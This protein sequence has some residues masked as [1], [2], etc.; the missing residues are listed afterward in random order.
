MRPS[1]QKQVARRQS[2]LLGV[3]RILP[4]RERH[5]GIHALG[6]VVLCT[7][8]LAA[9]AG[10]TEGEYWLKIAGPYELRK[11]DHDVEL[12]RGY[13]PFVLVKCVGARHLPSYLS[14][15]QYHELRQIERY[16]VANQIIVGKTRTGYFLLEMQ[17]TNSGLSEAEAFGYESSVQE[18]LERLLKEKESDRPVIRLFENKSDWQAALKGYGISP[19]IELLNPDDIARTRSNRELRPFLYKTF[20][21][22]LGLEDQYWACILFAVAIIV[23]FCLGFSGSPRLLI[24]VCSLLL[25]FI[26]GNFVLYMTPWP[27][28]GT[29]MAV[30][31]IWPPLFRLIAYVGQRVRKRRM[32]TRRAASA[33]DNLNIE[34]G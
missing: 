28:P 27:E 15:R 2:C 6:L 16:A 1:T 20:R 9:Q 8:T 12:A 5:G 10:T 7:L 22:A 33:P 34:A 18:T 31:V 4:S 23:C 13:G 25:G 30:V 29:Y 24:S 32:E 3:K 14:V 11:V 26:W 21:G 17:E 19:D